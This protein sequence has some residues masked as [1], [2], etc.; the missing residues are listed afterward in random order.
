[1]KRLNNTRRRWLQL[2]A[3]NE[4]RRVK[5]SKH[6]DLPPSAPV[7][8]QKEWSKIALPDNPGPVPRSYVAR[9]NRRKL[10]NFMVPP[11]I[12]SLR[13]NYEGVAAF[14]AH[15]RNAIYQERL[16]GEMWTAID[17]EALKRVSPSAALILAAELF[18]WQQFTGL[19]LKAV[20][21][22]R[23]DSDVREVLS[24]MG[25]FDFLQTPNV[26]SRR[27]DDAASDVRVLKYRSDTDVLGEKCDDLLGH[28]TS[29]SGPVHAENFIYDG[30]VEALKNSRQ[31]AY[32]DP[33]RWFGVEAGTWFMSGSFTRSKSTLTAAVF[34][35][36]VGIPATLPRT[37]LWENIRPFLKGPD[38]AQMIAAAME[39]GR[40]RTERQERGN[41]IP[42]M[43]RILDYHAGYLRILSGTGEATYDSITKSVSLKNHN[44]PI[45]GTLI[46]WSISP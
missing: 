26:K 33:D 17:F 21:Q 40:S 43:M 36:G 39:Y 34:D 28:L 1:M 8:R 3:A 35:L 27:S 15:L 13:Q 11:P 41:G 45:G 12:F 44:V 38:D 16:P 10:A 24:N 31:H 20:R 29:I 7:L 30:L 19:K 22:N 23:W 4:V 5:R 25:L 6:G 46:E 2:R 18:R 42:T 9:A 32:T 14:F 37:G